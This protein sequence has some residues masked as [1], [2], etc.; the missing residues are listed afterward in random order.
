MKPFDLAEAFGT[1]ETHD[2]FP[3]FV[4]LEDFIGNRL[5]STIEPPMFVDAPH[6]Q[7]SIYII[8]DMSSGR[9]LTPR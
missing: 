3:F 2:V 4:A 6:A 1:G 8:L 9:R 7:Y 5:Y